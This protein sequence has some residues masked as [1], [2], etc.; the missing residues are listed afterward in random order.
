MYFCT[1]QHK[2]FNLQ[3]MKASKIFTFLAVL[4]ATFTFSSC[5]GDDNA[6]NLPQFTSYVTIA[7]D[8]TSGYTFHSDFGCTLKPTTENV[9]QV[10][11]VLSKTNVKRALVAFEL[12]NDKEG[13]TELEPGKTYDIILRNYYYANFAIPTYPTINVTDNTMATDTLTANNDHITSISEF[14]AINGFANANLTLPFE[15][16]K[17]FYL[18][19]F[20]NDETDIDT[21][22]NIL[23]LN[24]YYNHNSS[25][26][27]NQGKS[28]FSFDL[29][30]E[31]AHKFTSESI[32]LVLRAIT[33]DRGEF[34][35][36]AKCQVAVEELYIP[37]R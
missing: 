2:N 18:S 10:L 25:S 16:N 19:T 8:P 26:P 13:I 29:P 34:K 6:D 1:H 20:Y 23:Y 35:E 27:M 33:E 22:N 37:T 31:V 9:Q 32:N 15:S 11:P 14:W 17:T 5:L 28:V 3:E 12:S 4:A 24:L 7:G 30:E 21:N 36:V